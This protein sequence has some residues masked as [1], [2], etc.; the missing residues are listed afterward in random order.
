MVSGVQ[1]Q[2][3]PRAVQVAQ[4]QRLRPFRVGTDQDRPA[5]QPEVIGAVVAQSLAQV[6]SIAG[7]IKSD[8]PEHLE[9]TG[10]LAAGGHDAARSLTIYASG[11][12]QADQRRAAVLRRRHEP[13]AQTAGIPPGGDQ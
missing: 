12:E 3:G 7:W 13:G 5:R 10:G 4:Q 8:L 1:A 9:T 11:R 6:Q 2:R